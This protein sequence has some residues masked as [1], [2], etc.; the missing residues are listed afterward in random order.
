MQNASL[1][2]VI[3]RIKKDLPGQTISIEVRGAKP[4]HVSFDLKRTKIGEV[5]TPVAA[6][7]GCKLFVLSRGLLI[8]PMS[9][10]T[11]EERLDLQQMHG[12][13]W[14]QDANVGEH[15]GWTEKTQIQQTALDQE[16]SLAK[17]AVIAQAASVC[18]NA[19]DLKME[20][21]TL[22]DVIAGIKQRLPNH[23]INLE[24]RGD[25]P[26]R[27]GFDFK[28][29]NVGNLLTPVAALAG[30]KLYVLHS[31]LLIAPPSQ[32]TE[33][34]RL[35]IRK[36][37]GGEWALNIESGVHD[38]AIRNADGLRMIG[39]DIQREANRLFSRA[40]AQEVTGSDAK[41]L[42]SVSAKTTF[43]N[44]SPDSQAMLQQMADWVRESSRT[45]Y[46]NAPF[47][48]LIPD[49]RISISTSNPE[50]ISI[51]IDGGQSDPNDG[52]MAIDIFQP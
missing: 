37:G 8:S 36:V 14:S 41:I 40:I 47:L 19:I 39:W 11:K 28:G 25:S 38:D 30:C 4:V 26:V 2:D 33:D 20:N 34:E 42:P 13:E 51:T 31:G 35:D 22:Q 45:V 21:A 12:G 18:G 1:E 32:L 27:V 17:I 43:G 5:L 15:R 24:V 48:H 52:G 44:F 23:T 3:A 50:K 49:S 29:V 16:A 9:Q 10:L 6:L 46:P 7:A